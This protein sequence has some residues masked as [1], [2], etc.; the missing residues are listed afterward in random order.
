MYATFH[1]V[2]K[3]TLDGRKAEG[4]PATLSLKIIHDDGTQHKITL[5]ASG[6]VPGGIPWTM[7]DC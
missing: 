2:L 3:L 5:F 4:N 7:E 1:N 6:D